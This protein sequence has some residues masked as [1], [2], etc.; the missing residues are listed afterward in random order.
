MALM[1]FLLMLLVMTFNIGVIFMACLGL[2]IGHFIF[3]QS[4]RQPK[5]PSFYKQLAGS[6]PYLP[7]A[8]NCCCAV[9]EDDCDSCPRTSQNI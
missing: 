3:V 6:G 8:D 2:T 9:V 1:G 4:I 5:L 7:N